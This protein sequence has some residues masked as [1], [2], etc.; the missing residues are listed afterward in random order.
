MKEC[1]ELERAL[2]NLSEQEEGGV[3]NVPKVFIHAQRDAAKKGLPTTE[4]RDLDDEIEV[5]EHF[6][7]LKT[8]PKQPVDV[9]EIL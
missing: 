7:S 2:Y 3:A 4:T 9:I 8:K 6:S 1:D 5:L